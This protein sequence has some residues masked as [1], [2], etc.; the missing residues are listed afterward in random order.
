[1]NYFIA[2]TA[3]ISSSGRFQQYK[4]GP[5][6]FQVGPEIVTS[7]GWLQALNYSYDAD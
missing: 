6:F 7:V 5:T 4:Q 3:Q 2:A 1:M